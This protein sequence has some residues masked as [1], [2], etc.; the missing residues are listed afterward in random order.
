MNRPFDLIVI[1]FPLYK[2]FLCITFD[3]VMLDSIWQLC[4]LV[5]LLFI[6][7]VA[8]V[9]VGNE[10]IDLVSLPFFGY[11]EG[12]S[13]S[14]YICT[15]EEEDKPPSLKFRGTSLGGWL[16]LEPWITPSLFY[17]FLSA[18]QRFGESRGHVAIDS[19][20]FCTVLGA[21]EANRQL[22][23]HWQH[24]IT[25]DII[26]EAAEVGI[27][28]IRIPIAD[29][30]FRPYAPFDTGCWKGSLEE[31]DRVLALCSKYNLKVILDI[32]AGKLKTEIATLLFIY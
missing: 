2:G 1:R 11:D 23:I 26:Q 14:Q 18:H 8:S 27:D 5:L 32:H 13:S 3:F 19:Y 16:V 17:Q 7:L 30:M 21:E 4:L 6:Y 9:D 20:T 12:R 25:E 22:R 28:S 24:W 31:L 10:L 15:D 29:W